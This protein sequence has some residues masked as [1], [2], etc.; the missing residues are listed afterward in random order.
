MLALDRTPLLLD[1]WATGWSIDAVLSF[2]FSSVAREPSSRGAC[3]LAPSSLVDTRPSAD[4]RGA[5]GVEETN[6]G[7]LVACVELVFS[8]VWAT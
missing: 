1:L 7:V 5:F 8:P 4:R 2:L 6:R 3:P